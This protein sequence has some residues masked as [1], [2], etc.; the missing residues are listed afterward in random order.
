MDSWSLSNNKRTRRK[1]NEL[2]NI[3]RE[4]NCQPRVIHLQSSWKKKSEIN[5]FPNKQN[6]ECLL[7]MRHQERHK[8]KIKLRMKDY[9]R[10][11]ENVSRKKA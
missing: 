1:Q 9:Y 10:K 4:Y 2:F 8:R 5:I 7:T 6:W 11:K 3:L